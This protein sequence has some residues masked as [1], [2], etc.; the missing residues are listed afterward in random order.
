[1]KH[2]SCHIFLLYSGKPYQVPVTTVDKG[3]Q[4]SFSDI[5]ASPQG[6]R[7]LSTQREAGGQ[8]FG[9][10][11]VSQT[12]FG[13]GVLVVPRK[14]DESLGILYCHNYFSNLLLQ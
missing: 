7:P 3:C 4:R 5:A 9:H 14:A 2:T 6:V 10:S 11:T 13:E 12:G 1:M 8:G